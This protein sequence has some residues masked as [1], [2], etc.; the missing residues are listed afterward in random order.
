MR[1]TKPGEDK[2]TLDNTASL[3]VAWGKIVF[4]AAER[5]K[6][7]RETA[8]ETETDTL[9]REVRRNRDFSRL[10]FFASLQNYR[11]QA[12]IV[13]R[14]DRDIVCPVGVVTRR[15]ASTASAPNGALRA[16]MAKNAG[17]KRGS[18]DTVVDE[19]RLC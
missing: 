5:A 16:A 6:G 4:S 14:A 1:R 3:A 9:A 19:S 15:T 12:D 13:D 7:I 2:A 8:R 11:S 18:I 17:D 10:V